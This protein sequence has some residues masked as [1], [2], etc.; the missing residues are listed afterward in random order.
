MKFQR[1]NCTKTVGFPYFRFYIQQ[2]EQKFQ[3]IAVIVCQE[4][5]IR[6][7]ERPEIILVKLEER[8]VAIRTLQ[9]TPMQVAPVS[10]VADSGFANGLPG[11]FG[12]HYR[13]GKRNRTVR[14]GNCATVAHRLLHIMFPHFYV[15]LIRPI[16]CCVIG[17]WGQIGR[18]QKKRVHHY[19]T[20]NYI[21]KRK[22]SERQACRHWA[23]G[24]ME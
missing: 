5:P 2:T 7:V 1:R 24:W 21:G 15:S 11:T 16:Q 9:G 4:L 22:R 18:G 3:Q 6:L 12:L 23:S 13:Y 19:I 8:T 20:I 10:V 14:T 17:N